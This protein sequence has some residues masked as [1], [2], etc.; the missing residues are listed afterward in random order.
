MLAAVLLIV[1]LL[2][3]V[4]ILQVKGACAHDVYSEYNGHFAKNN[5]Q[6]GRDK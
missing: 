2:L 1:A 4:Y 3:V 5:L 6:L